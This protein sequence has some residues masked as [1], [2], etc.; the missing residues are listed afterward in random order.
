MC[1]SVRFC[2]VDLN[3]QKY[4][5]FLGRW[6]REA[7]HVLEWL[8]QEVKTEKLWTLSFICNDLPFASK[9]LDN[10][11][12]YHLNSYSG[13]GSP[14]SQDI[15]IAMITDIFH[16][17]KGSLTITSRDLKSV[18]RENYRDSFFKR[19]VQQLLY[20]L[21]KV[22]FYLEQFFSLYVYICL[23]ISCDFGRSP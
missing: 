3:Q 15:F 1:I 10:F 22:L 5:P 6:R 7:V 2:W 16:N 12:K 13:C 11:K 19:K 20:R 21:L 17:K 23:G 18:N 4:N 9:L 14:V 8:R